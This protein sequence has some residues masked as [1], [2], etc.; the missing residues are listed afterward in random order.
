MID[1]DEQIWIRL[2]TMSVV[3]ARVL[4]HSQQRNPAIPHFE[5]GFGFFFTLVDLLIPLAVG[6]LQ[7]VL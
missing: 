6:I 4:Q 1:G 5:K 2:L 7:K 3:V